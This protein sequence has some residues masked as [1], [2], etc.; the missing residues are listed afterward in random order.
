MLTGANVEVVLEITVRELRKMAG[1]GRDEDRVFHYLPFCFAGSRV[2]LWSQ[3]QRG[4][5][6]MMSMDLNNLQQEMATAAPHYFMNVPALLER[7]KN[8]VA[9]RIGGMG[10]GV[11]LLSGRAGEGYRRKLQG[12]AGLIDHA[13]LAAGRALLF[14][15]IKRLIGRNLEFLVCGSAPLNEETQRWFEMIGLA[16]YQ[17]YGL[18]ETTAIVTID[19]T[20]GATPG[21]VGFAIEGCQIRVSE[22]GELLCRGPNVFMGYWNRPEATAEVLREGW[23]HTGDQAEVDGTGSV[24]IIGRVKDVLVPESGHNIAPA[25][26]EERLVGADGVE[27]AVVVGHGRPFLTAIITGSAA[28]GELDRV[29]DEV[30]AQL[31]H[32]MRLRK[33]FHAPEP[34]SVE[35]G[36]LTANQKI[37]RAAIEAHYRDA[38]EQMYR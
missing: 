34:F 4:N 10:A 26:L 15:R 7:I 6:L 17:V 21:R 37:K 36:L 14:P 29:R 24:R 31:P 25:P 11:R 35:N 9:Q 13:W 38:I 20:R 12:Q 19:D 1:E 27:Q 23:L 32:Y 30:N 22:H 16:V 2:M 3:L 28:N 8:G 5:P 18:T 33:V